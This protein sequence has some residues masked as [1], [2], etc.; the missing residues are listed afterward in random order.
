MSDAELR[1]RRWCAQGLESGAGAGAEPLA[2]P[3]A[4]VSPADVV[5]RVLAVQAQDLRAARRALRARSPG[6]VARDVDAAL[7]RD[8]S[9]VVTWL[10]RGTLHLV[11]PDD[12]PW[13][14]ALTAATR[15]AT[16]RRRLGQEGVPPDDADRAVT[17]VERALADAGPLTRSELAVRIARAG[18]RTEGQATPHILMLAALR[19]LVVLAPVGEDGAHA[20]ALWRDW[21]GS[22]APAALEGA[23]RAAALARLARRYL[24]GH[25]PA[26]DADLARWS[27]LPLRDARA[28]LRAIGGE[29]TE[30]GGGRVDLAIR[31][32]APP[33][34]APAPRLLGAFDPYVLGWRDRGFLVAPEH[35]RRVHPGAGILR[36]AATAG[37]R[38][39]GTWTARRSGARLTVEIDPFAPLDATV[40]TALRADAADVARFEGLELA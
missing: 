12:L 28:G 13:L 16:S 26:G 29:L 33:P 38:A 23:A 35:A 30:L 14:H 37:G 27:G 17:T 4:G 39:V 31:A 7:S 21:L 36:A 9:L 32:A 20:F 11:R 5:G 34:P 25:G 3:P 2:G 22:P 15:L 19:G 6:L 40:E 10:V 8:R 24:G 1:A 18:I